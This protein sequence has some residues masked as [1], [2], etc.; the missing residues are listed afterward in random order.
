MRSRTLL[1]IAAATLMLLTP[2]RSPMR[3]QAEGRAGQSQAGQPP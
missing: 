2:A 1:G 3:A